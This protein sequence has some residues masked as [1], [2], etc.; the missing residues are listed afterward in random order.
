MIGIDDRDF[1]RFPDLR[2]RNP[3]VAAVTGEP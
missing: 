2:L 1:T 3:L